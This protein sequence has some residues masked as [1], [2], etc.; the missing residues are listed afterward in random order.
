[1]HLGNG[2]ITPE[3]GLF[4]LGA[5]AASTAV[6]LAFARSKPLDRNTT[7]TAAALGAAVFAAQMFNVQILPFSSVHLIGGVLLAWLLGPPLGLAM[8]MAVLAL[9]AI[10]LGDG[11]LLALGVNVINMGLVPALFVAAARRMSNRGGAL[12]AGIALAAAAMLATGA[13]AG[14]VTIEV[15]IGRT[16]GQLEGWRP[17]A[18]QMLASH[19]MFGI[20]E[21]AATLAIVGLLGGLKRPIGAPL[22]LP[23]AW[24]TGIA[25]A[26]I[27]IAVLSG[28][29][30]G[31]A[32]GA[33][34]GYESAVSQAQQA[35][36][37]L[38]HLQSVAQAGEFNAKVQ[39][40]QNRLVAQ[41]PTSEPIRGAIG[42][43]IAGAIAFGLASFA[44]GWGWRRSRRAGG[45]RPLSA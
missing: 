2:A 25:G 16:A 38:G 14:L 42:T 7:Y 11:G 19:A 18:G 28:P 23:R 40:W 26:A 17:F 35:G 4:A 15:A 45:S 43:F 34:D 8:M 29:Q 31:L 37:P 30:F 9:E 39:A 10:T 13:A 27:M 5:A 6:A 12:R 36:S 41:M 20:L 21:A 44:G 22:K 1:M 24:S 32:S 3:C 33:P